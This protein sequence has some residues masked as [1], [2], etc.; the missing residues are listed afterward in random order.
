MTTV[1]AHEKFVTVNGVKLRYL[2]WGTVD[3][4][5]TRVKE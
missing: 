3:P 5:A 4:L 1:K 2:D